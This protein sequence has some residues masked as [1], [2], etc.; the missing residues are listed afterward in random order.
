MR[1]EKALKK[2]L[3][4]VIK[5]LARKDLLGIWKYTH[6]TWGMRQADLY[7][8]ELES[9]INKLATEPNTGKEVATIREGM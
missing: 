8:R 1:P 6:D 3:N 7:L 9:T 5:P 4:A 2:M